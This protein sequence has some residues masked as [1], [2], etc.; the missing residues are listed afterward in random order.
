MSQATSDRTAFAQYAADPLRK[1]HCRA[2][3]ACQPGAGML[4]DEPLSNRSGLAHPAIPPFA[5]CSPASLA[6]V[7]WGR[8]YPA[9][10]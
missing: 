7:R 9:A 2:S 6:G 3:A 4:I 1:S 8:L 5:D 10:V